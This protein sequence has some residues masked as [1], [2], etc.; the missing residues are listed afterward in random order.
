MKKILVTLI[1]SFFLL[2]PN[3][4][5]AQ[6]KAQLSCKPYSEFRTEIARQKLELEKYF[7][8]A[9]EMKYELYTRAD[10]SGW[11]MII[12]MFDSA[13]RP[14]ACLVNRGDFIMSSRTKSF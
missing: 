6:L 9:E 10:G 14:L 8:D 1:L 5:K 4:A 13:K 7:L 12:V 2:F 3:Y 11:I